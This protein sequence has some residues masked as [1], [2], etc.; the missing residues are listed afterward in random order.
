MMREKFVLLFVT[1]LV[2]SSCSQK[3]DTLFTLLDNDNLGIDFTNQLN[4]QDG[5]NVF[6]FRNY[7]N[8]GGVAIGD[9]NNDGLNDMYLTS[10]QG[11]N[12]LLLNKGNWKF[13]DIADKAGVKGT[14][15]WS[16]GVTLVDV[17]ADGWLDIYVCNSGNAKGDETEN[18]LFIN[19]K[20]GTFKEEARKYGLADRGLSTHAVFFDYDLD[21]D[22]DCYVLNNSFR[23]I[24]SFDFTRDL[25]SVVD[26]IGG[27]R[28]YRND[29][30]VYSNVTLSAGIYSSDIGF[31][32]GVSSADINLDGYPD[33]YVSN[34]FFERDYLYINQKNGTFKEEIQSQTGHVSLASMGSDIADINND[35]RYDIFTTEMLPE[36]DERLKLVTSFETYD[37]V[38]LK[39]K[40]GYYNQYMQN[41]LQLNNGN[42]TFSEIAF[43]AGI[44]ATDW[45]WG[46]LAFDM[47]NDGW[48][49]IFVSNGIYKDLT[50]QDYIEFLASKENMQKIMEGKSFDYKEFAEKMQSTPI[51]NYA[52]SNNKDLTFSNKAKE[53]GLDEPSFSNGAAYGDL[54]NDG[55]NDLVVNNVNMPL[56][57]YQNTSEKLAN[58]FMQI[59]LQGG[60]ANRY[61]VGTTVKTFIEGHEMIYYHQPAR[62][63]QSSTPPNVLTIG[64]GKNTQVDSMHIIWPKGRYQSLYNVKANKT[65]SYRMADAQS[66]FNFASADHKAFL[67]EN[68]ALL[69]DRIPSHQEND[70]ID[71]DNERLMLQMLSTENPAIA[72]GDVNNDGLS[73]FYFGSSKG[74]NAA[75]Y[76][77]QWEGRFTAYSPAD[78]Q[79]QNY[80]ETAGAV[81]GDFDSDGD[82]DLI[83][84]VGGNEE[85]A[86]TSIYYP[87]YFE[88]D[89]T[90]NFK[91]IADKSLR[92]PVNASVIIKADY[93]KDGD[94][95]LFIGGR[96][97][98]QLYGC[99][100]ASYVMQNDGKGNFKDLSSSVFGKSNKLG[101]V[102]DAKWVDLDNNGLDD[103]VIAGNWMG[104]MIFKNQGGKFRKDQQLE[105]Y[106]GWWSSLAVDDV[107]GNGYLDIIAGNLGLNTKFTASADKPMTIYIKDFDNNGTKECVTSVYRGNNPYVF[108]LRP[109]LVGQLPSFKKRFLRYQDYAGKPFN[110]IFPDDMLAGAETHQINYLSS[111][112]FLNS[113]GGQL[114]ANPLPAVAQLSAVNS[115]LCEDINRDGKK[116][117][118]LAGNFYG[119]KPEVGRLDGS[120]GTVFQ[121]ANNGFKYIPPTE[122]GLKLTGQVRSSAVI[123]N[124]KGERA[125]LFGRNNE[126]LVAYKL[127]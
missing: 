34:D 68:T 9:L 73:D 122:S 13:E 1:L 51:S 102:T 116:E 2:L 97:V 86:G 32:L 107:D 93:D 75:I 101:M 39:Q 83:I 26:E 113:R 95:D 40:D 94:D 109:D 31:G 53:F 114:S 71:F 52:Y 25:R 45:S 92:V 59:K 21:G 69:F 12:Q 61:G 60:G 87:R 104:I 115:I 66:L 5:T 50:N 85:E 120:Y 22:L 44:A 81:F 56:F 17:N 110:E 100:P 67:A 99:S 72:V 54:D 29:R 3:K 82:Q 84:A 126:A 105:N 58:N 65:Y 76:V 96:S 8:G 16:T 89:G 14:K 98:P 11:D 48:K 108:H 36:S 4:D 55:D 64:L 91:R 125:L 15:Y 28:L 80:L 49:D 112:V 18:E 127:N 74:F 27:D 57:V 10:N 37:I 119:F 33:L 77:Q 123:S 23:P 106:R 117:L 30:G 41:C 47:D 63:F 121:F 42:G 7:Y 88:N 124:H 43:Y 118:I 79:K 46:A 111:A 19:Q 6:S 62:G 20:N 103:L 70:F 78:F 35:G 90:G 38:K 24:G